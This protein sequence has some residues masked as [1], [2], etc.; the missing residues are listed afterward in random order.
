MATIHNPANGTVEN[1][2]LPRPNKMILT[3]KEVAAITGKSLSTIRRYARIGV[4]VR[5]RANGIKQGIGYTITSVR[6]LVEGRAA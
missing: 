6:A 3:T 4:L 1:N 5:I 2:E